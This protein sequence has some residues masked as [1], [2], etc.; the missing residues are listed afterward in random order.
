MKSNPKT[1]LKYIFLH[2]GFLVMSVAGIFSKLAANSDLLS[3]SFFMYYFMVLMIFVCYAIL[4]QQIL[5][6]LSLITAYF[7][8]AV[9]IV[10]GMIWGRIF[11]SEIITWNMILGGIIV[12][13]G[14]C[15]VLSG[16]DGGYQKK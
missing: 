7:N 6:Q 8:K 11:F 3:P 14:I 5:K 4:W 9:T 16:N 10:W 15:F 2:I 1:F 13:I 12:F